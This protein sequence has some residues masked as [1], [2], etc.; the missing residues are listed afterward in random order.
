MLSTF[1]P[2]KDAANRK[3]RGVSFAEGDGV[4]L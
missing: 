4:L 3:K 1:D 2:T